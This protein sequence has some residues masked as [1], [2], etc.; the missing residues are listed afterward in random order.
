M[1]QLIF[2]YIKFNAFLVSVS[3]ALILCSQQS[4]ASYRTICDE[5]A[6][7]VEIESGLPQNI[8]TSISLVEAGRRYNDGTVS[9]WPWSLNHAGKSLFFDDKL[10]ALKYLKNNINAKFKNIDVGCMQINVKWHQTHFAS[11][12][13]MID[14]RQNIEYAALFLTKLKEEH[15][16]WKKAIKHYHSSTPKLNITYYAK[17]Q[18]A[19]SKKKEHK[20]VVQ[21]VSLFLKEN[22]EYLTGKDFDNSNVEVYIKKNIGKIKPQ[23]IKSKVDIIQDN[24]N[25]IYLNATFIEKNKIRNKNEFKKYLT[26]NSSYLGQKIDMILFFRKEF[27]KE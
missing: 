25:E 20:A 10:A 15:G 9:S 3:F 7:N 23:M 12:S 13:A 6:R 26:N 24:G 17:V 27:S 2:L 8:L 22:V 18:E 21:P 19:W 1:S 14:P 4:L 16:S 5:I 11:F